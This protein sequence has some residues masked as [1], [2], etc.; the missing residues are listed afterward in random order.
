M[1]EN[2]SLFIL[3]PQV[4]CPDSIILN[5]CSIAKFISVISDINS[6]CI[7]QELRERFFNVLLATVNSEND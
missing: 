3:G 4:V 5:I 7:R 1:A 2:Q 6:F